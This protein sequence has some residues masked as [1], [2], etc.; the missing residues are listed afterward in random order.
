MRKPYPTRLDRDREVG[1]GA[2]EFLVLLFLSL[3]P[4][5]I[6]RQKGYSFWRWW[7]FGILFFIIALPW[8]ILMKKNYRGLED[9]A[10]ESGEYRRC[11]ECGEIVRANAKRCKHCGA[12]YGQPR[13]Q[14]D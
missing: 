3:I 2:Q 13:Y 7:V 1:V 10:I 5:A 9:Q 8:A 12:Q 4:A 6:A 11:R 14:I